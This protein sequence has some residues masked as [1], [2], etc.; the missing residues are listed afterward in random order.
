MHKTLKK[1]NLS[2]QNN[3]IMT[4]QNNSITAISNIISQSVSTGSYD[5]EKG[6]QV[7]AMMISNAGFRC[8]VGAR[9]IGNILIEEATAD[10]TGITFFSGIKVFQVEGNKKELIDEK[11]FEKGT[12]YTRQ[13]AR[14]TA[15][16]LIL[17]MVVD[18]LTRQDKSVNTSDL[19][20]G[21]KNLL[22]KSYYEKT[23]AAVLQL[24]K[25]LGLL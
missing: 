8:Q 13:L 20:D 25:D 22:D 16:N 9:Q 19:I 4:D 18:A 14:E 6:L 10:G 12:R 24:V 5:A 17:D 2:I 7:V 15:E 11:V 23:D 21:V 3:T 1:N